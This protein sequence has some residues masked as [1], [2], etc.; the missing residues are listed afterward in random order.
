VADALVPIQPGGDRNPFFCVHPAG[1]S[2]LRYAGLARELGAEQP[3]YGLQGR[4]VEGDR[5]PHAH[6]EDMAADYVAAIRTIQPCGPYLLGGWSL[7]GVVAFEMAQL[8]RSQG[9]EVALLALLDSLSPSM[10]S[11]R[12]DLGDEPARLAAFLRDARDGHEIGVAHGSSIF[13][14]E[15]HLHELFNAHIEA[16]LDYSPE[17]YDGRII[18]LRSSDE[19]DDGR[20]DPMLGWG[21]LSTQPV[22]VYAIPGDHFTILEPPHVKR[23]AA[24]LQ[25]CIERARPATAVGTEEA[26]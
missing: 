15:P 13:P 20:V 17:P 6:I 22:D 1:G 25:I 9:H 18:L 8:L 12:G 7:G 21:A 19:Y 11:I 2:V 4:G 24:Q 14:A 16:L 10:A 26:A 3:F 23:L 5:A